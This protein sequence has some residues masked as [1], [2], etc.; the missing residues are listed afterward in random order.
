METQIL[1]ILNRLE[2]LEHMIQK[3]IL[4]TKNWL[5]VAEFVTAAGLNPKYVSQLCKS[6]K[7]EAAKSTARHGPHYTWRISIGRARGR[8]LS[9]RAGRPLANSTQRRACHRG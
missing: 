4:T 8:W 7:I 9:Q 3:H 6:G 2:R 1:E 5:T